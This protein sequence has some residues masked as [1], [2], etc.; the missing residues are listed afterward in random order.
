[1]TPQTDWHELAEQASKELD[2]A[3]LMS[4][5]DELNRTLEQNERLS[6]R[7]QSQP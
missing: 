6:M 2:P 5:V 3:K 1:M 4:L 7:L